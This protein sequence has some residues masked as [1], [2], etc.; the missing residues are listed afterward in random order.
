MGASTA[1]KGGGG[2]VGGPVGGAGVRL[3]VGAEST[4]GG[5]L[6]LFILRVLME[7]GAAC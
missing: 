5:H 3:R 2:A 7:A 4:G 1:A 6:I